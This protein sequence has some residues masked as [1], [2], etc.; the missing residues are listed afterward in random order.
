MSITR[1]YITSILIFQQELLPLLVI[2]E[3]SDGTL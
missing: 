1:N 2:I 3:G